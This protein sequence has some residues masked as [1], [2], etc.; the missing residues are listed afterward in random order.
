[1]VALTLAGD[2]MFNKHICQGLAWNSSVRES[3]CLGKLGGRAGGRL[4]HVLWEIESGWKGRAVYGPIG[5][6]EGEGLAAET[7]TYDGREGR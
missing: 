7:G 2:R 6:D 5:R 4:G 1:M 3:P